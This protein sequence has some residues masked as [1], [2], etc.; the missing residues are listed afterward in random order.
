MVYLEGLADSIVTDSGGR[1][2]LAVADSG[3]RIVAVRHRRAGLLGR[4]AR[5]AV[6][7]APRDTTIADF[8]VPSLQTFARTL[9]GTTWMYSGLAGILTSADSL[10]VPG[11]EA[12][13]TWTTPAGQR[14]EERAL[15]GER[16]VFAICGDLPPHRELMLRI[17]DGKRPLTENPVQLSG[18]GVVWVEVRMPAGVVAERRKGAK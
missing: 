16:G 6:L 3:E 18:D 9:C 5:R 1:F 4:P 11:L 12:R 17:F 14:R 7:L 15:S 13:V 10:P 2:E 8:S